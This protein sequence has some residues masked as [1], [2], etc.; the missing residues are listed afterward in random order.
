MFY[1][2]VVVRSMMH[3]RESQREQTC[4]VMLYAH[5]RAYLKSE[6]LMHHAMLA[7]LCLFDAL[8]A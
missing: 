3:S 5:L 6:L 4:Y 8:D 2:D 7:F 1:Q